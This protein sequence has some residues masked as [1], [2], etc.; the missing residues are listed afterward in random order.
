[1]HNNR[2]LWWIQ[3]AEWGSFGDIDFFGKFNKIL[4]ER[5]VSFW[6]EFP[7]RVRAGNVEAVFWRSDNLL[8]NEFFMIEEE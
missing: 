2:A 4:A 6:V 1:M 8:S 7:N 5:I 3:T